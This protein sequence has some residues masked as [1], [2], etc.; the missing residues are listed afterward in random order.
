[1]AF[2]AKEGDFM[3]ILSDKKNKIRGR[4]FNN[5]PKCFEKLNDI[6][7]C[8]GC[9]FH[10]KISYKERIKLLSDCGTFKELYTQTKD[11]SKEYGYELKYSKSVKES[12]ILE[13]VVS[14][15]CKIDNQKVVMCIMEYSFMAGTLSIFNGEKIAK[16]V[17]YATKNKL[18]LIIL[19]QSGGARVQEGVGALVQMA[20]IVA[21]LE[22]HKSKGLLYISCLLNPTLGGVT[23]SFGLIGDIN[24]TEPNTTIGFAGKRVIKE[25]IDEDNDEYFQ[26]E[27]FN[28]EHGMVD[29]I[30]ERKDLKRTL[31]DIMKILIIKNDTDIKS[32]EVIFDQN[33]YMDILKRN[34]DVKTYKSRDYILKMFDTFYELHGDRVSSEDASIIAGIG[35]INGLKVAIAAQSKGRNINENINCNYGMTSPGG[36]RKVCRI[37]SLAEKFELP[38]I[39]FVDT[40]GAFPGLK[41]EKNGQALAISKCMSKLLNTKTIILTYVIGEAC[42]GGALA[43]SISDYIAMFSKAMYCVISPE[44]YAAIIYKNNKVNKEVLK[45][46][47]ASY[48]HKN[49][50][51]DDVLKENDLN[52]NVEQLKNSIIQKTNELKEIKLDK[53]IKMRYSRIRNWNSK[54]VLK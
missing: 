20:K 10:E 12:G 31:S 6:G 11:Y 35:D 46:M 23:A 14:G 49:K 2:V 29:I 44:S 34:R 13:A 5:C 45:N 47:T 27:L 39:L 38:L 41:A 50:L 54:E 51:I 21:A 19:C 52:Y 40:P 25:I 28:L 43:L 16:T 37:A 18:P 36:Y 32:N 26:S 53:L 15:E 3:N 1:M 7:V 22:K 42:S 33:E 24:I 8:N 17:E 4:D 9:G 48:L 30:C